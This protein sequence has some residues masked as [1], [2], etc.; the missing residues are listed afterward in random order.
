MPAV[1]VVPSYTLPRLIMQRLIDFDSD[2]LKLILCPY[3]AAINNLKLVYADVSAYEL[4]TGAG[5]T[6][7]GKSLDFVT[8]EELDD[9]VLVRSPPLIWTGL[10]KT[11][12]IA[13][14]YANV[15]R[16]GISDP[17]IQIYHLNPAGGYADLTT[18]GQDWLFAFPNN[19][20]ILRFERG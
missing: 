4:T 18:T 19:Q 10:T 1:E 13:I 2:P 5:Y 12:E 15:T 6:A 8:V 16:G 3:N 9:R 14:L 7:G 11:F 20:T 17:L